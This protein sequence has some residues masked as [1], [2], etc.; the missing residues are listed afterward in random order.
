M[1]PDVLLSPGH[2]PSSVTG[3]TVRLP[4]A[5]WLLCLLAA[6]LLVN[7]I[8]YLGGGGDDWHYLQAARC[9]AAEG[10]CRPH[11][12]WAARWPLIAPMAA[13]LAAIGDYRAAV[14]LV[15]LAYAI[16]AVLLFAHIVE[17]W[18]GATAG[19]V[20]GATL[21][22]TPIF[23]SML[24]QPNADMV[25]LAFLL[26]AMAA[27]LGAIDT[28]R[29]R[30]AI[31]T[32]MAFALAVQTRETSL[33]YLCVA[34]MAFL[35]SPPG[36]QRLMLWAVPGFVVPIGLEA[37]VYWLASGDL[38]GRFHLALQHARIPSTELSPL[39]DTSRSPLLN[40]AFIS[41][42]RP[43][44][45][46][47]LHWSINGIV[48]LITHDQI[49]LTLGAALLLAGAAIRTGLPAETRHIL[50]RLSVGAAGAALLLIYVLCVDPKPRMFMPLACAAS[51]VAATVGLGAW[52]AGRRA[53]PAAVAALLPITSML[54]F[55][56]LPN[57]VQ[58]EAA[59]EQW[60]KDLGPSVT[61]NETT[62]RHLAL[63][64]GFNDAPIDDDGRR[65]RMVLSWSGCDAAEAA[66]ERV[67]RSHALRPNQAGLGSWLA[68]GGGTASE[69]LCLFDRGGTA[70]PE[71]R[72]SPATT[73]ETPWSSPPPSG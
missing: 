21:L 33:V 53:L 24:L 69:T 16:A 10:F 4:V 30:F 32:G 3:L 64:P 61:T 39:V 60:L 58:A 31:L 38:L 73:G 2:R 19:L 57:F 42:W 49:G 18:F 52:R 7:P 25:E 35:R 6:L 62:H 17:R 54:V 8:G 26:G 56:A 9:W 66:G 29:R 63:V 37:L 72:S 23:S 28:G 45:G 51:V 5:A 68:P 13:S 44:N 43:A 50:A 15:P 22:L 34:A 59:A 27:W 71:N 46:I 55:A 20:A 67:I 36:Q 41:G 40:P 65:Y 1:L 12:H 48:N 14:G 11:D 47:D 70:P